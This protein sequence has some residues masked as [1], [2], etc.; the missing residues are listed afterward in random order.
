MPDPHNCQCGHAALQTPVHIILECHLLRDA[1]DQF[2][3]PALA[4]L[5]INIIFGT[6][7]GGKAL[8]EFI[9]ATQTCMRPRRQTPEDHG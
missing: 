1:R 6:K 7:A 4:D 9:E 8:A 3:R 5:A 2:L